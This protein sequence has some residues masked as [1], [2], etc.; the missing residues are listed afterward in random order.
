MTIE[1]PVIKEVIVGPLS[2]GDERLAEIFDISVQNAGNIRREMAWFPKFQK[3]VQNHG[4]NVDIETFREYFT[5]RGT[6]A[7]QKENKEIEKF[8]AKKR[9][10]KKE[11]KSKKKRLNQIV[12]G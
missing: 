1:I 5:Y 9:L 3:G 8:K 4:M 11:C 12:R 2:A 7:W 6:F 10:E